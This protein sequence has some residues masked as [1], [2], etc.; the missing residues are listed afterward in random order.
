MS[1]SDQ[2]KW[3]K[4]Y[5]EKPALLQSRPPSPMVETFTHESKGKEAIDL[6]CGSG[7]NTL[8]LASRGFHVD[9]IDISTVALEDLKTK[10][11]TLDVDLYEADLDTFTP[12]AD[13]YDLAVMTNYLDRN[14]I[15][16]MAE[17]LKKSGVFII[18]TYMMHPENEKKDSNPDFLLREEELL[19]FFDA[20][21]TILEYREFWNETHELYKMRKQGI[22][23]QK[24]A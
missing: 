11:G 16:R 4:K 24:K 13:H 1:E 7:K 9:A 12:K 18:E 15:S 20:T 3:N 22:A 5:R 21:F 23:V 17:A 2:K 8:F 10:I 14:L 6:A 19:S